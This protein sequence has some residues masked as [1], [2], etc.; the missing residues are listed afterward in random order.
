MCV[1]SSGVS[2]FEDLFEIEILD[3]NSV[4]SPFTNSDKYG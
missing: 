1:G 4:F 3:A 2:A